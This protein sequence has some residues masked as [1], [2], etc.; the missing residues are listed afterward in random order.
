MKRLQLKISMKLLTAIHF[1][2]KDFTQQLLDFSLSQ[3]FS[4]E[5]KH[6]LNENWLQLD[7]KII[8]ATG[9]MSKKVYFHFIYRW[10]LT[11]IQNI[12]IFII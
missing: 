2:F 1:Y 4:N 6:E 5:K 10:A 9:F 3:R 8:F 11:E 7:K 12:I